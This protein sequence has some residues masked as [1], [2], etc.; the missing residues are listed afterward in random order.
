MYWIVS[1]V[2][3]G[4][5]IYRWQSVAGKA[6][7]YLMGQQSYILEWILSMDSKASPKMAPVAVWDFQPPCRYCLSCS[8]AF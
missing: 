4:F 7:E 3:C 1:V 2:C 5:L 6:H 8:N